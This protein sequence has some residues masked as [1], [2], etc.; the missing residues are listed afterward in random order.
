MAKPLSVQDGLKTMV[1]G[2]GVVVVQLDRLAASGASASP[3]D[4]ALLARTLRTLQ[5]LAQAV[6]A[7]GARDGAAAPMRPTRRRPARRPPARTRAR[8]VA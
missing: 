1:K 5:G 6:A 3:R 8:L 2:L 4:V 7:E